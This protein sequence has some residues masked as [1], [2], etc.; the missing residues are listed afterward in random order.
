MKKDA[1]I[2]V[3]KPRNPKQK[4]MEIPE[5]QE[6]MK[7][8]G[9][10]SLEDQDWV[11]EDLLKIV[12]QEPALFNRLMDPNFRATLEQVKADPM[13]ALS[14]LQK[15]PEMLK[16]MQEFGGLMGDYFTSLAD[17]MAKVKVNG[18]Q[19]SDIGMTK[20]SKTTQQKAVPPSP[21]DEAKMKE[22]LSDPEVMKVLQD[23]QI[24]RLFTLMKTNP[25]A[26]QLEVNKAT[27][28]M[29]AKLQKLVEVGL[30]G[31]A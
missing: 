26:A 4:G 3:I 22:I 20:R 6:A 31:F 29:R 12:Q 15:D 19:G 5:V 21:E 30:L 24:Q 10:P 25:E 7:S 18:A 23:H 2:P 28:E 13:K 11:S 8:S 17:S 27:P 16:A 1:D 14:M 9:E